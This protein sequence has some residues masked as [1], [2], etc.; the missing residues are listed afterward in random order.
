MA[1]GGSRVSIGEET[2]LVGRWPQG[3]LVISL[4]H[5][6]DSCLVCFCCAG[7]SL[8]NMSQLC[9]CICIYTHL[10]SYLH[11]GLVSGNLFR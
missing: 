7:L 3:C 11:L 4:S 5:C 1:M 8:V 9:F 2:V 10:D 6:L